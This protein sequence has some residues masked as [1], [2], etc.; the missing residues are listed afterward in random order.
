MLNFLSDH[1]AIAT[2]LL[3]TLLVLI[4]LAIVVSAALRGG[5]Q[6]ASPGAASKLR[7]LGSESLRQ[8]FRSAVELI[9]TNLAVRAERYNLSWTLLLNESADREVPLVQSGLQSALSADSTLSAAAEG[10]VW[11]FF[12]RGVVVQLH[13]EQL[14]SP[15]PERGTSTGVWDD[16]LGLCRAYRP[17]RPFDAIVLAIPC[18]VLLAADPQGQLDL[19]ARA[20]A[21]HRR[22]WLAQ[23]RLA[24]RLPIHLVITE[25]EGLP[26]F[27][28]FGAAL[29][30]SMRRAILGWASPYEL[31]AP[32]R[33]QWVDAAIDQIGA[34]VADG[35]AELCAL[36]PPDGNSSAYF[37]L[38]GE[39]ERLRAGLKLFCE[40]LMRPSAYHEPFLLRGMYLTG[41]SSDAAALVSAAGISFAK[42][43]DGQ[44]AAV[45]APLPLPA[46]DAGMPVFLRDIFERKI[47]AEVGL[48]QASSQRL[49]RP[50]LNRFAYVAAW[51]VPVGW[52]VGLGFATFQ[53]NQL[54]GELRTYLQALDR[55]LAAS[56]ARQ[57]TVEV[58]LTLGQLDDRRFRSF[59]MPGSWAVVDDV[60]ERL[61]H[62]LEQDFANH[63]FG[64]LRLAAVAKMV[65]LTGVQPDADGELIAGARCRLPAGWAERTAVR[66]PNALN[67]EDLRHY[68]AMLEYLKELDR[69]NHALQAL[70]RLQKPGMAPASG[71]DLALV[72]RVLLGADLRNTATRTAAMFRA[73]A[74]D[75]PEPSLV[76]LQL[77]ARCSLH[78]AARDMYDR[79][80]VQNVL[81]EAEQ[82]VAEN[83]NSL[84]DQ[85]QRGASLA[86]DLRLWTNM[87][88]ALDAQQSQLLP[89]KGGWMRAADASLGGAHRALLARIEANA[90]LGPDESK[91]IERMANDG[92]AL[93]QSRWTALLAAP[94][95]I[96]G[97]SAGLAWDGEKS[98]WTFTRERTALHQALGTLLSQP[99]M[100]EAAPVR[101][102]QLPVDATASWDKGQLERAASMADVRKAFQTGVWTQLPMPLQHP[103]ASLVDLA[104]VAN[105]HAAL[106]QALT[107]SDRSLP[108]AASD[109]ERAGVLRVRSLLEELR[110][111]PVLQELDAVLVRDAL[112]RLQRMDEVFNAAEVFL[113]RDR[114]LAGWQGR[115]GPLLEAFAV[116]DAADLN[117]YVARQQEFIE[118]A[119]KQVEGVL[120]QLGGAVAD[121]PLVA[122]WQAMVGDLRRYR[123]KSPT[124]S[125]GALEQ[126]VVV[127]S[128]DIDLGNCAARLATRAGARRTTDVFA[129][130]LHSLQGALLAR[131]RELAASRYRNDWDRFAEAYNR[132]LAR[133][134]PFAA[135]T[136]AAP[137]A[138][139]DD[140]G[141]ALK[142]YDRARAAA[143][144]AASERVDGREAGRDSGRSAPGAGV[145]LAEQQFGRVRDVLAPLYPV[146]EGQ[147]AGLDVAVQFRANPAE[148]VEANKIIDWTLSVGG[149]SLRR[150][151]PA[152]PLRWEPG[153]P[154]VLALRLARDGGAAP[155]AE[156][157][158]P[159]MTVAERTVTYRFDDPWAL[160]SFIGAHRQPGA[161]GAEDKAP[162]LR[163]EF[164]LNHEGAA[165]LAQADTRARVFLRLNISAPGK[166]APL[167]WPAV[168]PAQVPAWQEVAGMAAEPPPRPAQASLT[169]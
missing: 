127:G 62:R 37:L 18:A 107:V 136:G 149:A 4:L 151:D 64:P 94:N 97:G 89:G 137:A 112:T 117:A 100:K 123:L 109:A 167:S 78:V 2:L 19:A 158:Q 101:L 128:A 1:L 23:N 80:F 26:G 150:T 115:K 56:D 91:A 108:S 15:D 42:P 148:E 160:F 28:A 45:P 145:R 92:H 125:L 11:N 162:L 146:E 61:R 152:R 53:L 96:D 17:Q 168:F 57:R 166:R 47:F 85:A 126:F 63:A 118:I 99:Y 7:L 134:L 35:C 110:A 76:P 113:P 9:E 71:D 54:G 79:L 10:M 140:V 40:E 114:T 83:S 116:E 73:A 121:D 141:A 105:V 163:F 120:G 65:Q 106:A 130:R 164:P 67:L 139:L 142:L 153:Q 138:D 8:S 102:A 104:L 131:C 161:A 60:H 122:R 12:D 111:R 43:A 59:F 16:F 34:A 22:L 81:L 58:L 30:E 41:D 77:A 95:A 50:A 36:T 90:L 39:I 72:V 24:L 103:A 25:C 68:V 21:I 70:Q 154:V 29:P 32:F 129:E 165:A 55:P 159:A 27:A 3:V 13:A 33:S 51:A 48:V 14:G 88:A 169:Q 74:K 75:L 86:A 124:S 49:R 135:P 66:T 119:G 143:A 147:A 98:S 155:R 93:L 133:R 31:V 132:D 82:T 157:G 6:Q 84:L 156:P 69:L 144:A 87:R 44:P 20:K 5:G 46:G 52:A 38:P